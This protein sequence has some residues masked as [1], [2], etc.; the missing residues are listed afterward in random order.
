VPAALLA[1]LA[2]DLEKRAAQVNK[3]HL[4]ER[5]DGL[6]AHHLEVGAGTAAEV[7]PDPS[8]AVRSLGLCHELLASLQQPLAEGVVVARLRLVEGLEPFLM[9]LAR[10]PEGRHRQVGQNAHVAHD[11]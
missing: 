4:G 3:V 7:H 11:R 9:R 10:V 6:V 5:H 8:F 2:R 1:P